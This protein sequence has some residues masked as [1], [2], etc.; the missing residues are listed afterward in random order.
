[1]KTRKEDIYRSIC[2]VVFGVVASAGIITWHNEV[3]DA[4]DRQEEVIAF[5]ESFSCKPPA[6]KAALDE[7][8]Y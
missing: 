2:Y 5:Y 3:T 8:Y 1:M 4:F 6:A 7:G